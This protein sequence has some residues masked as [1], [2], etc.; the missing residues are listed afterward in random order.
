MYAL[1]TRSGLTSPS[2]FAPSSTLSSER[3]PPI[4]CETRTQKYACPPPSFWKSLMSPR[5]VSVVKGIREGK[6][7][8]ETKIHTTQNPK[9]PMKPDA[10]HTTNAR[11]LTELVLY[12]TKDET[13]HAAVTGPSSGCPRASRRRV[14]WRGSSEGIYDDMD[15]FICFYHI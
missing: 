10:T 2:P 14:T 6:A 3:T 11:V 8:R 7:L 9:R 15:M 13:K 1:D 12:A 4:C 5:K